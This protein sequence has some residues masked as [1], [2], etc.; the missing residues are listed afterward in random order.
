MMKLY[1]AIALSA[2]IAT[3][4]TAVKAQVDLSSQRSELQTLKKIPGDKVDHKGIIINPT[5]QHMAASAN[6]T[7]YIGEGIK[8]VNDS[9]KMFKDDLQFITK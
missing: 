7:L 5:P 6:T 8:K 4:A 1:K 9:K 2:L 3:S